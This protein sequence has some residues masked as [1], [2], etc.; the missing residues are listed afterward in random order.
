MSIQ[1][2]LIECRANWP[3][4]RIILLCW[5]DQLEDSFSHKE[6]RFKKVYLFVKTNLLNAGNLTETPEL[7]VI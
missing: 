2:F 6:D 7:F 3:T 1:G 4:V 5:V